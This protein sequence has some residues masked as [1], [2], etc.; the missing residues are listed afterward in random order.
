MD[1]SLLD[2]LVC[3]LTHSKLRLEGTELVATVGGL[4]YPIRNGIPVLLTS[5]A[6]LPE[7]HSS[8]ADF[9]AKFGRT[10]NPK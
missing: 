6:R 3:P 5:E 10:H 2:L 9:Q 8:L 4:R 1:Q 7:G